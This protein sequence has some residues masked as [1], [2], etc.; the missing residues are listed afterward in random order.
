MAFLH[1]VLCRVPCVCVWR[2]VKR[3]PWAAHGALGPG[4]RGACPG[5]ETSSESPW[6]P[7]WEWCASPGPGGACSVHTLL[8]TARAGS[9]GISAGGFSLGSLTLRAASGNPPWQHG[10]CSLS[11][12]VFIWPTLGKAWLQKCQACSAQGVV[13][14]QA[15]CVSTSRAERSPVTEGGTPQRGGSALSTC[16][17]LLKTA[18]Q[19]PWEKCLRFLAY[20]PSDSRPPSCEAGEWPSGLC[21]SWLRESPMVPCEERCLVLFMMLSCCWL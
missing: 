15:A 17:L 4:W 14:R 18:A 20:V 6:R 19:K 7:W 12:T 21:L 1:A 8:L 16:S 2:L 3:M 5:R 10:L 13:T 9:P 11:S